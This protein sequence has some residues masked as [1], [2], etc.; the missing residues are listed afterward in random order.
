MAGLNCLGKLFCKKRVLIFSLVAYAHNEFNA[1][2]SYLRVVLQPCVKSGGHL[3]MFKRKLRVCQSLAKFT[4]TLE[5]VL[6]LP[7]LAD[8]ASRN[9]RPRPTTTYTSVSAYA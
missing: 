2:S 3:L 9:V 5:V 4:V 6:S 8:I 1:F 7:A